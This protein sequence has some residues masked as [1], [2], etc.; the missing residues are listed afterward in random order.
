MRYRPGPQCWRCED[1]QASPELWRARGRCEDA[2]GEEIDAEMIIGGDAHLGVFA[3][4]P[5]ALT[6]KHR[7]FIEQAFSDYAL[8]KR[9]SF[10]PSIDARF[11]LV[12]DDEIAKIDAAEMRHRQKIEEIRRKSARK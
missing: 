12:I 3:S 10:R 7:D 6:I 4:C 5:V 1:C 2:F 8:A 9:F 11:L